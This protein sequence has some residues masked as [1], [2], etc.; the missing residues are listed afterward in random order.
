MEKGFW[1]KDVGYWQTMTEPTKEILESYPHG[2][3]EIPIKP[4]DGYTYDGANWNA[5]SQSWLYQQAAQKIRFERDRRLLKEVDPI[6]TNAIRWGELSQEQ[7]S[8]WITYRQELLDISQQSGFPFNV[9]W[10]I[11]P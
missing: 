11:K 2:T 6:A 1:H 7:K 9:V 5:P 4:G 8:A 10:P 3:K